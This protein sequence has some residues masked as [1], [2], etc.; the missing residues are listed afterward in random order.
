MPTVFDEEYLRFA[1]GEQWSVIKFDEHRDYVERIRNLPG[2]KA[3]D[4]VA[5]HDGTRLY[6]I[7]VKDFRG[8]RI[9]NR[10]RISDG[11]LALEV[12]QKVRDTIAGI[13]AAYHRGSVE[14]WDLPVRRLT[15]VGEHVRV[16]LWLEQDLPRAPRGR[17]QNELSVITDALKMRL[18]WLTPRVF[19]ASLQTGKSPDGLTVSNLPGAGRAP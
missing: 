17:R 9:E 3:L 5:V 12:G 11:E 1:F 6:L 14:D 10:H 15:E 13:V 7:E 18:H 19:V 8:H 16:L 4:F 2:T